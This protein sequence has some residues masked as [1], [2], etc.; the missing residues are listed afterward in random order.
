MNIKVYQNRETHQIDND[1]YGTQNE[2]K[3]TTLKIEVPEA[4]YNTALAAD[5]S[6]VE[7]QTNNDRSMFNGYV[8]LEYTKT[9]D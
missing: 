8:I 4:F 1:A 7:I 5:N 9:T 2:N 6:I 3:V